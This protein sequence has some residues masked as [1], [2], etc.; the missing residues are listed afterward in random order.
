MFLSLYNQQMYSRKKKKRGHHTTQSSKGKLPNFCHDEHFWSDKKRVL[1]P[2]LIKKTNFI[3][4][5][6]NTF[7][8]NCVPH[9]ISYPIFSEIFSDSSMQNFTFRTY[10]KMNGIS[11]VRNYRRKKLGILL[12]N[13]PTLSPSYPKLTIDSFALSLNWQTE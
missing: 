1:F 13:S 11:P 8:S 3:F 10:L 5:L 12:L 9:E 6:N 7:S 2:H 4:N